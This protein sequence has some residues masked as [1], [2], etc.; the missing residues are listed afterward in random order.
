MYT[1][2]IHLH[3]LLRWFVIIAALVALFRAY[4]GWFSN[5]SWNKTDN[6]S[7]LIF[8]LVIDLQFLVGVI[9]Y[10][11]YSPIVKAAF[12]N[13]GEAIKN[14]GIRFFAVE[15][16]TLMLVALILIHIGRA[17]SKKAIAPY[18]Q[19]RSAA[20]FYTIAIVLIVLGIPWERALF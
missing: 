15:N 3:N 9:L 14:A 17:K 6:L 5:K 19:H 13:F 20:I 1:G 7:G 16:F 4:L 10:A 2:L 8:T 18:K 11:F 12:S